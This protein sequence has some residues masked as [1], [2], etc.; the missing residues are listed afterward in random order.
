M[1]QALTAGSPGEGNLH[2]RIEALAAYVRVHGSSDGRKSRV[3]RSRAGLQV[4]RAARMFPLRTRRIGVRLPSRRSV[5]AKT[6][7]RNRL[8]LRPVKPLLVPRKV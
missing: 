2:P 6:C 5:T 7:E 3:R 4:P 8:S 1:A